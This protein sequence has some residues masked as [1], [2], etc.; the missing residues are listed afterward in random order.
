LAY[1]AEEVAKSYEADETFFAGG[2][3][4][5]ELVEAF[6]AEGF[7]DFCAGG[8]GW[9]CSDWFQAERADC[10]GFEGVVFRRGCVAVM[11]W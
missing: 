5:W 10:G 9:D 6:F 7:D 1:P 3:E 4:D 8:I 11:R 2:G